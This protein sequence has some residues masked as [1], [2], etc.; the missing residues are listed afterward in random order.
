MKK[1][2]I[3]IIVTCA[4]LCLLWGYRGTQISAAETLKITRDQFEFRDE[5]RVADETLLGTLRLGTPVEWSGE[6]SG[7]WFRVTA[8]NGQTGWVHD[9]GLSTPKTRVQ[10]T[11]KPAPQTS[12]RVAAP[13]SSNQS[14]R[15]LRELQQTNEQYQA[16][17][18]EKNRRIA[19]LT[20]DIEDLEA[21][22]TDVAQ[23]IDDQEQLR[24]VDQ[25]KATELQNEL[26]ALQETIKQKDEALLTAKVERNELMN[27]LNELQSQAGT[28]RDQERFWL[29]AISLPLNLI[30]LLVLGFWGIRHIRQRKSEDAL[31]EEVIRE[32]QESDVVQE[33]AE[34]P[35]QEKIIIP[36][37]PS[38]QQEQ[39]T[40]EPLLESELEE[41]DVVMVASSAEESVSESEESPKTEG[42]SADEDVVIDLADV[43][44][45]SQ[46]SSL[47]EPDPEETEAEVLIEDIGEIEEIEDIEDMTSEEVIE[48][49]RDEADEHSEAE[50]DI[51]ELAEKEAIEIFP[52]EAESLEPEHERFDQ[53]IVIETEETEEPELE[54]VLEP[55]EVDILSEEEELSE[56]EKLH[57]DDMEAL[58][59][60]T[61]KMAQD[62]SIEE[63]LEDGEL[64]E[65]KSSIAEESGKIPETPISEESEEIEIEGERFAM[66]PERNTQIIEPEE[67]EAFD[68]TLFYETAEAEQEPTSPQ[69]QE[70]ETS[71]RNLEDPEKV[72]TFDDVAVSSSAEESFESIDEELETSF[73]PEKEEEAVSDEE[74]PETISEGQK[75]QQEMLLDSLPSFLEPTPFLIE[76]EYDET[77]NISVASTGQETDD[78]ISA[79]DAQ[80][81]SKEPRYDIELTDVGENPEH[82]IHILSKI[83]GLTK[84]P[85]E[86]VD[87]APCIIARGAKE[88]DAK[89]FQIVMQ[90]FGSEV[91]L[92]KKT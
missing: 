66:L 31:L 44:P 70:K 77:E 41:L 64:E 59:E 19:Q 33:E 88:S 82:I 87:Q 4:I 39:E 37:V 48:M 54:P 73:E 15:T 26:T 78:G 43:L 42:V 10:P 76:P 91:Q 22:L 36:P 62:T 18:E 25:I 16:S 72:T 60:N 17:L 50:A 83:E 20:K 2:G 27:Q 5:P 67:E 81:R 47:Q 11:P 71:S 6:T 21:K 30:G 52:E 80:Q 24:K 53:M 23:L 56:H 13:A 3:S 84:A 40:K 49:G 1:V 79:A 55:E 51:E 35:Q 38:T 46:E 61:P 63:L 86:L 45:T 69:N 58:L 28:G 57:D 90:K 89:N 65:E 74:A 92:I 34:E 32:R 29:Y 8:P 85:Q 7:R 14:Q 9:S 12:R 75:S 68:E